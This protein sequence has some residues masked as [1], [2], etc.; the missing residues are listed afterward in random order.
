MARARNILDILGFHIQIWTER[1]RIIKE[2]REI[3]PS[4]KLSFLKFVMLTWRKTIQLLKQTVITILCTKL[5]NKLEL[6]TSITTRK[7]S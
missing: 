2:Q 4:S 1:R 3:I 7:A 6:E 5:N